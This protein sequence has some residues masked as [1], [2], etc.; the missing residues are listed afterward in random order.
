MGSL[1]GRGMGRSRWAIV[2]AALL[3]CARPWAEGVEARPAAAD[4]KAK[5][6]SFVMTYQLKPIGRVAKVA[7]VTLVPKTRADLQEVVR[8]T[9]SR[10]P[11]R[12]FNVGDTCY[13]EW[14][15]NN[16]AGPF[17]LRVEGELKL[18]RYDL[19]RALKKRVPDESPA[20][21][22]QYLKEERYEEK[23]ADAI[24]G[25]A[26]DLGGRDEI[27]TL[28]NIFKF[29][30]RKLKYFAYNP[31]DLGAVAGLKA[32]GGDCTEYSDLFIALCRAR[33]IPA[34]VAEGFMFPFFNVSKHS[35]AEAYVKGHGWVPFD[36]TLGDSNAATFDKL[37]PIYIYLS[38]V[39]NDK[40]LSGYHFW[41]YRYW[42]PAGTGVKVE[43][44]LELK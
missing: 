40:A 44:K 20:V 1:I 10:K 7:F 22:R 33:G 31:K 5:R 32:G 41:A 12:L 13:A 29:V 2:A 37:K 43:D 18:F 17:E 23:S 14:I 19:D 42:G 25:A 24:R 4:K 39:R 11:T 35:W 30:T 27:E 36:P 8:L 38:N 6:V 34:R 21:L 28:R 26:T 15:V 3:V 9:Y 16:P